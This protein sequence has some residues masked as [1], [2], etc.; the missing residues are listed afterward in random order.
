[1]PLS[2][3]GPRQRIHRRVVGEHVRV[4]PGALGGD[5]HPG[6]RLAVT[7]AVRKAH[8]TGPD[9]VGH[10]D[11]CH[12]RPDPTDATVAL[13][14][15]PARVGRRRRDGPGACS[16]ACP[17]PAPRR[18]ASTSCCCAGAGARRARAGARSSSSIAA[19]SRSRSPIELGRA[20]LDLAG[21]RAEDL[22]QPRRERA[23]VDDRAGWP[24]S[25]VE[26]RRRRDRRRSPRRTGRVRS[27]RSSIRSGPRR[28]SRRDRG[29][30]LVGIAA[31]HD[32]RR[33][34]GDA[35]AT[36]PAIIWSSTIDTVGV[37][38]RGPARSAPAWR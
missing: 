19:A 10:L 38:A 32:R 1:M 9:R 35:A 27:I 12:D 13:A 4:H 26:R 14:P 36:S 22:G 17:S 33:I 29:D 25:V 15:S 2:T 30:E 3:D 7:P 18:C 24:S 8:D 23:V 21:R 31:V 11:R 5:A 37:D 6:A 20:E 34:A 16:A 28:P